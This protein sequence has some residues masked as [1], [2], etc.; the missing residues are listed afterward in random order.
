[1]LMLVSLFDSAGLRAQNRD[2]AEVQAFTFA[3]TTSR[4]AWGHIYEYQDMVQFPEE[5]GRYEKIIMLYTLKCDPATTADRFGCGEWDYSTFT[6]VWDNDSTYWEIGRFITPYGIGLDLGPEGFTWEFDVTDYGPVLSGL[7]RMTAGN[8]QE[9]LD[10]KFLFIK[11]TPARD[12]LRVTRLWTGGDKNYLKVTQDSILAPF[13]V[14]LNP[15]ASQYRINTRPQGGNFNG[16]ANTDNCSEFCDREHSISVDGTTRFTWNVW[17]ECGDNPVFPQGGSWLYDRAGWCPGAGVT[18]QHHELTPFVSPGQ[19]IMVDYS[20]ENPSQFEPYGHWVFWADLISYGPPNFVVDAGIERIISPSNADLFSRLNPTCAGPVIVVEG[21][22]TREVTNLAISYGFAGSEPIVYHW[23][24]S[25]PYLESETIVLPALPLEEWMGGAGS[26]EVEILAVNGQTDEYGANNRA[27]SEVTIP[28]RL[29]ARLTVLLQTNRLNAI[30]TSD[31]E[32]NVYD[33]D[34]ARVF[35]RNSFPTS[36]LVEIPLDLPDG[37]YVFELINPEGL[38]LD[39][40]PIRDQL[41]TGSVKFVDQGGTTVK[42]FEP[43]FGNRIGFSFT[44][45][46][47]SAEFDQSSIEFGPAK[48]GDTVVRTLQITPANGLGLWMKNVVFF[49]GGNV[50]K[51]T[52]M[53]PAIESDSVWIARGDTM[54]VTIEFR[55]IAEKQYTGR[56]LVTSNDARGVLRLETTG[57][58]DNSIGSVALGSR[59]HAG[60]SISIDRDQKE[61]AWSVDRSLRIDGAS[62][63]VYNSQGRT[64]VVG[65]GFSEARSQGT[66][67]IESL[68][69]GVYFLT[70]DFEGAYS[71]RQFSISR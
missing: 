67:A 23:V 62:L 8:N 7:K 27:S 39:Y 41:G 59:S 14:T 65:T 54:N 15:E 69:A 57:T 20:I 5:P 45:P 35:T 21:R 68:P 11:G 32:V 13:E 33:A 40:W 19:T 46:A 66:I 18:T 43:D 6:R 38:G 70:V 44:V 10:L 37:C 48:V 50:F 9:L 2:T 1:M 17:N 30:S 26:F 31:Y 42:T 4:H 56:L 16:G 25:I 22:G 53:N 29:P 63:K 58:G 12:P 71:S 52:E 47:P 36:E 28:K 24:G 51:I 64:M 3:D 55:P 34:G 49:S 60:L 61:L